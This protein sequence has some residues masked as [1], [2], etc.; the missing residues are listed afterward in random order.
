MESSLW[1]RS[2]GRDG[3]LMEMTEVSNNAESAAAVVAQIEQ[4][5]DANDS[6]LK[7]GPLASLQT[8]SEEPTPSCSADRF[9]SCADQ[10]C[11]PKTT[12]ETELPS[13]G[14]CCSYNVDTGATVRCPR[15]TASAWDQSLTRCV[16][17]GTGY[18]CTSPPLGS[19]GSV[20]S[21]GGRGGVL[22]PMVM[23]GA[24]LVALAS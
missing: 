22:S 14:Q 20:H 11:M 18:S 9:Y 17:I 6:T 23:V 15:S 12:G 16:A 13:G 21:G 7:T 8:V 10:T 3:V 4:M 5:A 24:A 1:Q 19:S 2:K